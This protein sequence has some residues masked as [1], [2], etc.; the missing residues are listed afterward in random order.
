[1]AKTALALVISIGLGSAVHA[2]L[3]KSLG[4]NDLFEDEEVMTVMESGT[5]INIL[6]GDSTGTT[7]IQAVSVNTS[8][9]TSTSVDVDVA[10]DGGVG[11]MADGGRD[12]MTDGGGGMA[13]GG[14]ARGGCPPPR[15]TCPGSRDGSG[16]TGAGGGG[17]VTTG[18]TV[19][20]GDTDGA[21][22]VGARGKTKGLVAA[23]ADVPTSSGGSVRVSCPAVAA[24]P[25]RVSVAVDVKVDVDVDIDA[26]LRLRASSTFPSASPSRCPGGFH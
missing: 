22:G 20:P 19:C 25:I 12:M 2:G 17:A 23:K 3:V 16:G 1:M 21:V 15:F 26:D 10:I 11:G 18:P 7:G 13:G 5:P 6:L 8:I 9:S 4:M 14:G 24:A